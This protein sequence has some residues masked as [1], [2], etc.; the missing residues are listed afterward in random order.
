M[1]RPL[2]TRRWR[3]SCAVSRT[4]Q[5]SVWCHSSDLTLYLACVD[6]NLTST[7]DLLRQMEFTHR[8]HEEAAE[9]RRLAQENAILQHQLERA[10][11]EREFLELKNILLQGMA[12]SG[13]FPSN[14]S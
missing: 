1:L 12:P 6:S 2:A 5:G 8:Q 11:H 13:G 14:G 7:D 9:V 3:G 10:E 4:M